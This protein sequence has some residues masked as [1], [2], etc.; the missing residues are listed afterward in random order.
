MRKILVI[1]GADFH[2]NKLDTITFNDAIPCTGV[3]LNVDTISFTGWNETFTLTATVTPSNT[4]DGKL[5]SSSNTSVATVSSSG[6]VTAKGIGTTTIT[7]RCGS[8]SASCTVTATVTFNDSDILK[9]YPYGVIANSFTAG[10]DAA[11]LV[12]NATFP[13]Y[14]YA[15]ATGTYEVAVNSGN[16][17]GNQAY[18]I[19]IPANASTLFITLPDTTGT[20]LR[21]CNVSYHNSQVLQTS[22]AGVEAC[23]FVGNKSYSASEFGDSGTTLTINI[24]TEM[25]N[26]ADSICLFV[27]TTGSGV[28]VTDPITLEFS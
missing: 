13:V 21:L 1:S 27:Q 8:Q 5:W 24:T 23:K 4:T 12:S 11:Q 22:V 6:V 2:E 7:V 26:A 28:A 10:N 16:T 14:G 18:G 25:L 3:Q 19:P 15:F 17:V 9:T 20:K